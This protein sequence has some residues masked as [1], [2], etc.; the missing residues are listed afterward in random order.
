MVA[1]TL[2][3]L[4]GFGAL[5]LLATLLLP[6]S[7]ERQT[8]ELVAV[9]GVAIGAALVL[10][11]G[12]DSLPAGLLRSAP[13]LGSVLVGFVIYYA[14][15]ADSPAYAMYMAWVLVAASLFLEPRLIL[16]HGL[17]A[18]AVYAV[19]LV[20][21][22]APLGELGVQ[23]A[24]MVGTVMAIT[25]VMVGIGTHVRRAMGR[26]ESAAQT[27]PLTR[28]PNRRAFDDAF[29]RELA[30]AERTGAPLGVVIIDLDGFKRFND[31]RGH[32]EGDRAL[33][34]LG[35]VLEEKTR[36]I[37]LTARIGGEEFALL[38]PDCD[39]PGGLALAERLR[40]AVEVEFGDDGS[41]TASCGVASHPSDGDTAP[42]LIA[43]ADRAL[44]EAKRRGRNRVVG[45]GQLPPD[46]RIV[47]GG[48]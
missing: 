12:Y 15:P 26:L 44:Y 37:D 47:S 34:R 46:L 35:I 2:A 39:T 20:A 3:Y 25:F 41:L 17:L 38:V 45:A 23:I 7:D 29:R 22:D 28:L 40:R 19:A 13:F 24:M 6:D 10:I 11:I 16:T 14:D 8:G 36:A 42:A 27:D 21:Q 43:A 18:V 33:S 32:Q 5:L 1:R 48:P 30:R 4:F 9:A 31:Q